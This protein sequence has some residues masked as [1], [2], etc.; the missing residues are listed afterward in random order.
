MYISWS[1][2]V[3]VCSAEESCFLDFKSHA[4]TC[5]Q[6]MH[7]P[8]LRAF[9]A[10]ISRPVCVKKMPG[11]DKSVPIGTKKNQGSKKRAAKTKNAPTS[12]ARGKKAKITQV[13]ENDSLSKKYVFASRF[14]VLDYSSS[15]DGNE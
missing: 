10:E 1:Q 6:M 4:K 12:N 8:Y 11:D 7:D 2:H 14:S 3:C 5:K 9:V 13:A 15:Q